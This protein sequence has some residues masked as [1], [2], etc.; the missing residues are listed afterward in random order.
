M[1][2]EFGE[3]KEI[4]KPCPHQAFSKCLQKNWMKAKVRRG[5]MVG[6]GSMSP[7]WQLKERGNELLPRTAVPNQGGLPWKDILDPNDPTE[8]DGECPPSCTS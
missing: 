3:K 8:A 5:G 1:E 4:R 2:E 6:S 7:E